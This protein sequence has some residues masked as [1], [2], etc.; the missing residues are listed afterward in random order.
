MHAKVQALH[1]ISG[2]TGNWTGAPRSHQ[3]TWAENVG[4]SPSIAFYLLANK[5][6]I[7]AEYFLNQLSF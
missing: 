3:R 7:E 2:P 6:R 1:V 4:R 5:S